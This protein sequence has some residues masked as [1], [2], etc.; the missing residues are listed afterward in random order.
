L[1]YNRAKYCKKRRAE[2]KRRHK[3]GGRE[4]IKIIHNG[5]RDQPPQYNARQA[6][7]IP[8]NQSDPSSETDPSSESDP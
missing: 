5:L 1:Y 8:R 3:A 4:R 6:S 7:V 2:R